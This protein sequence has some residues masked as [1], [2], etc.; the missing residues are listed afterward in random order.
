MEPVQYL[1]KLDLGDSNFWPPSILKLAKI[2]AARC[3]SPPWITAGGADNPKFKG[4]VTTTVGQTDEPSVVGSEAAAEPST[5]LLPSTAAESFTG[6]TEVPP[7]SSS[8]ALVA[9]PVPASSP[10]P[11]TALTV[12]A[13]FFTPAAPQVPPSVEETLK[14]ILDNQK[15]IMDILV[16]HRGAIE[17]LTKQ[18]DPSVPADPAT[19]SAKTPAG[20]SDQPNSTAEEMLQMLTNP[21]VPQLGDDEIQLEET[22]GGDAASHPKT[23]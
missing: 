5:T 19:P 18:T 2:L 11:L 6:S 21:V 9:V 3:P 17:E 13:H 8:R 4:K 15:T 22:E 16:A 14:K 12:A 10:Y 20:Q 23:I 1:E 7:S